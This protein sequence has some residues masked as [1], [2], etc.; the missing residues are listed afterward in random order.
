MP[1]RFHCEDCRARIRVP[2]GAEGRN[3]RC[4]RCGAVQ[5]VPSKSTTT[6]QMLEAGEA[7]DL[8]SLAAA[9]VGSE[10]AGTS[11]EA[12]TSVGLESP[13]EHVEQMLSRH[14][15]PSDDA[16]SE[17]ED[18]PQSEHD[19]LD[20]ADP[21][22]AL[23]AMADSPAVPGP[24]DELNEHDE[25]GLSP[26]DEPEVQSP[27]AARAQAAFAA[28]SSS[29][30]YSSGPVP[31]ARPKP[32]PAAKPTVE[33]SPVFVQPRQ[34]E[35]DPLELATGTQSVSLSAHRPSPRPKAQPIPL[36][37]G[38]ALSATSRPTPMPTHATA[39]TG[40][41]P[42]YQAM[43]IF[44]WVLR[45]MAFFLVGGS[46]KLLL[47]AAGLEWPVS[48]CLFLLLAGLAVAAVVGAVG[49]IVFAVRDIARN[50]SR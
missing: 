19:D 5:R 28:A 16:G 39:T 32:Q 14:D 45:V 50:T 49:E 35:L 22:A 27:I 12:Q 41:A 47:V 43:L 1:I 6:S 15:E 33:P 18:H 8:E 30:G 10:A 29:A 37:S 20:E 46:V 23:A 25:P 34:P 2:D 13:Q 31:V 21:L 48:D 40:R 9:G 11:S 4:P 3:V 36:G 42:A 26:P 7:G 38:V 44:G 17:A 24:V